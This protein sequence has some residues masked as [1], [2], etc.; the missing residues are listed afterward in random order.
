M[1]LFVMEY[2][3][4]ECD[5]CGNL[6]RLSFELTGASQGE[7]KTG[8]P[9]KERL[10]DMQ[11]RVEMFEVEV[12]SVLGELDHLA[13]VWGDEGVFRRC[14]DRLRAVLDQCK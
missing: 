2:K 9:V 11:S 14:R 3:F 7:S 6:L 8:R 4:F 10:D 12:R 13:E 1:G 5:R